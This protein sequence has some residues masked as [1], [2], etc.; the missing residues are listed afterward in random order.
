MRPFFFFCFR[1]VWSMQVLVF[2]NTKKNADMLGRQLEQA[3][4][5]AGVLHG[6]KTQARISCVF[7]RVSRNLYLLLCFVCRVRLK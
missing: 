5:S 7:A 1:C 6:G 2:I 3:G 4:F